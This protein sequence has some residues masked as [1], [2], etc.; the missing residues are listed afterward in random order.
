MRIV[1]VGAGLAVLRAV[2]ELV[3]LGHGDSVVVVGDEPAAPYDRPPLSKAVLRDEIEPPALWPRGVPATVDLRLGVAATGVDVSACEVRLGDGSTVPYDALIIGTGAEPRRIPALEGPGIHYLRRDLDAAGLRDAV[4]GAGR[5]SI[6]GGGFIG[7]E[8]AAS[9]RA[10]D[11]PVTL[12]EREGTLMGS[13]LG[14]VV[15]A[16]LTRLHV[17]HGVDAHCG[18]SVLGR[19]ESGLRLDD[20]TI[21]PGDQV[22]VSVG[23]VP[24]S[25]WLRDSGV[26]L[27]RGAVVCDARGRTSA[28]G[29]WAVGDVAA[30]ADAAGAPHR[31]EH[32]T[33]AADQGAAV[34][35]DILGEEPLPL[36]VPYF[37]SDQY[38]VKIQM[39]G[40]PDT[41]DVVEPVEVDGKRLFLYLREGR[42]A[43]A[44]GLS[45]ARPLMRL[46]AAVSEQAVREILPV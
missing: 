34:A 6:L 44:V 3:R 10:L 36:A 24:S 31:H 38:D 13:V 20:G 1:C 28:R 26:L 46:R 19:D 18:A 2:D 25:G 16:E 7:C 9:L 27:E 42:L 8:V 41:G 15:G 43:A 29:V 32:W 39:L 30:W 12:I 5:L 37:W 22:L 45:A 14:P 23:A 11:V 21:V 40:L 35:R 17:E 33:S 4:R